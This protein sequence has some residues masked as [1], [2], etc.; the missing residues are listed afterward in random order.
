MGDEPDSTRARRFDRWVRRSPPVLIVGLLLFLLASAADLGERVTAAWGWYDDR[1]EWR[2]DEYSKLQQLHSDLTLERFEEVLGAP[3]FRVA[4]ED[5]R[6]MEHTFK[7]RDYWVQAV[8]RRGSGTVSLYAVTSC[9]ESFRPTFH[10]ADGTRITL[11]GSTLASVQPKLAF[12]LRTDYFFPAATAN[13]RF[14]EEAY[15]GNPGNYKGFVWGYN[16]ACGDPPHL[17]QD[18]VDA[19]FDGETPQPGGLYGLRRSVTELA[20]PLRSLRKRVVVN[21]FAEWGPTE[22]FRMGVPF[23]VGIDRIL[24]RTVRE[25]FYETDTS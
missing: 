17:T 25:P 24:I 1:F 6:W 21:T 2:D 4:S 16:D 9:S 5:R 18:E 19:V 3:W 14:L 11:N 12:D 13:M 15:G 10:L 8:T 22:Y 20:V 7:G 23:Q